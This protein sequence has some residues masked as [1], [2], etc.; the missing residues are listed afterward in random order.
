MWTAG[1][2]RLDTGDAV[3]DL[4]EYERLAATG[5]TLALTGHLDE[6]AQHLDGARILVT[7]PLAEGLEA[8]VLDRERVYRDERFLA[9]M[10][11]RA[12]VELDLGRHRNA[13]PYL[14]FV[15]HRHPLSERFTW[16]LMLALFRADRGAEALTVYDTYRRRVAA[17][18][19]TDPGRALKELQG[20]V[21]AQDP[22]WRPSPRYRD[23]L[24]R[25]PRVGE[26]RPRSGREAG[27]VPSRD[28][29][30]THHEKGPLR[31]GDL[32]RDA[33]RMREHFVQLEIAQPGR[34]FGA[35][36]ESGRSPEFETRDALD[37]LDTFE[38][39]GVIGFHPEIPYT[40]VPDTQTAVMLP[41]IRPQRQLKRH[42]SVLV[43]E[44]DPVQRQILHTARTAE[45]VVVG[46]RGEFR[47][48]GGKAGQQPR[49]GT[50]VFLRVQMKS[51]QILQWSNLD[52]L[53]QQP[54]VIRSRFQLS[55]LMFSVP[56]GPMRPSRLIS[57]TASPFRRL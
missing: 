14:C 39:L 18:L 16:L 3:T 9:D 44:L 42:A 38:T 36:G 11:L 7:G 53:H 10:E 24:P 46:I 12:E 35:P 55:P 48:S 25:E 29:V 20:R 15:L 21:L 32:M 19:G 50:E 37:A 47:R 13:V 5:T 56:L 34:P 23:G 51:V 31:E 26:V 6:A 57:P 33:L 22:D 54:P 45:V 2:Y 17:E 41:F 40:R 30:G 28:E 43:D 1:G 49:Q 27:P 52:V 8:P 4:H